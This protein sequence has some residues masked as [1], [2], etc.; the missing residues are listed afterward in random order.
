MC[1]LILHISLILLSPTK[2]Y[3]RC[4]YQ[5]SILFVVMTISVLMLILKLHSYSTATEVLGNPLD[6]RI[7]LVQNCCQKEENLP[8]EMDSWI[9]RVV[10]TWHTVCCRCLADLNSPSTGPASPSILDALTLLG[11]TSRSTL[12]HLTRTNLSTSQRRNAPYRNTN[13]WRFFKIYC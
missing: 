5:K 2:P 10:V 6:L 1:A 11:M 9:H 8:I 13:H 12:E 7:L 4:L 3:S